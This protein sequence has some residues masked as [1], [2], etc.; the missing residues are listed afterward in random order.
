M[1]SIIVATKDNAATIVKCIT[2]LLSVDY[3]TYE[4][5]IVNDGS[6]DMTKELLLQFGQRLKIIENERSLGPAQARNIAAQHAKGRYVAFTDADCIVDTRWLKE[7]LRGF[8]V[9]PEAVSCGG[10]Q[11]LPEDATIFEKKVFVLMKKAGFLTEY[12]KS[13]GASSIT[14]VR[15]N[16]SCN[17]MYRRDDFLKIGGFLSGLWPGE[18]VELDYRL[19][20]T[21]KKTIFNPKAI[22]FHY[23]PRQLSAFLKMMLRYGWA[24]G[25][26]VRRYGFFRKIHLLPALSV[27][28]LAVF[29]IL[30]L[31]FSFTWPLF[32]AAFFAFLVYVRFD[33]ELLLLFA[34]GFVYWHLGFL[35]SL[36]LDGIRYTLTQNKI[37]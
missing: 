2:S 36:F 17:V 33:P 35:K 13:S 11:L 34:L 16:A 15:H 12:I 23:R 14:E 20:K 27:L 24:Q 6:T 4:I 37:G 21:G 9:F 26:L 25:M 28:L 7:L 32:F 5:L 22:V 29:I 19:R 30:I 31:N 18:D 3:G 8:E 10:V 1:V